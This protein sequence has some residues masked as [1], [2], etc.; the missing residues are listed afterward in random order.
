MPFITFAAGQLVSARPLMKVPE[1]RVLSRV[2]QRVSVPLPA[3]H[4]LGGGVSLANF[5]GCVVFLPR[6][7]SGLGDVESNSLDE[8]KLF[9]FSTLC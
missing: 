8:L 2:T 6:V 4:D 1:G 5:M 9:I 3:L 7:I